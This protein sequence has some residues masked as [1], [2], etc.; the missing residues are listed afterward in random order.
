[1]C[2]RTQPKSA[3]SPQSLRRR[4]PRR[5]IAASAGIRRRDRER[6]EQYAW[7]ASAQRHIRECPD[8]QRHQLLCKRRMHRIEHRR[9]HD[10]IKHL[11]CGRHIMH[12]IEIEFFRCR[13][14]DQKREVCGKEDD[15]SGNSVPVKSNDQERKAIRASWSQ[16]ADHGVLRS[17]V[18][19]QIFLVHCIERIRLSPAPIKWLVMRCVLQIYNI[20]RTHGPVRWGIN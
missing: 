5:S 15:D 9:R 2:P 14:A 17:D 12:F 13:H 10:R 11:P 6:S 20:A 16:I 18:A 3:A 1:M 4:S 7:V 19:G 8:R